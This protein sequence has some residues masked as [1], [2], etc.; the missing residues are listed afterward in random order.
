MSIDIDAHLPPLRGGR[1]G[2]WS[3]AADAVASIPNGSRVFVSGA[4][5]TPHVLLDALHEARSRWTDIEIVAPYL[6]TR[7]QVFEDPGRPFRFVTLQA[8]PAFKYLWS[9]GAVQV[10]PCAYSQFGPLCAAGG[11]HACDVALLHTSA[12]GP[13]GRV[14][15]GLSAGGIVDVARTAPL[16]IAQVNPHVPYTLGASELPV[17]AFDHLV[18]V[19]QPLRIVK[20]SESLDDVGRRIATTAASFV[21]EGAAIQFGVGAMPDAILSQLIGRRGLRVHSGMVSDACIDLYEAGAVEGPMITAEAVATA[22]MVRWIDRN[23]AVTMASGA[24]THGLAVLAGLH[25]F[26]SLNS[27]VEIALDGAC[28]SEIAGGQIISGPGGAP[29]YAQA[30]QLAPEGRAVLALRSSAAK[31]TVSRI[32]DRIE[33][34]NPTTLPAYFADVVVTEHGAAEVRGLPLRE[35]AEALIAIADPA[36]RDALRRHVD[37]NR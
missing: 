28:N 30:A 1:A 19:D 5:M 9:S 26:T 17:E 33:A 16:V 15:L 29:D 23:P 20:D 10:L 8:T 7:P 21:R 22:R 12:P 13:D 32:V 6:T 4:A 37:R 3:S 11:A 2:R 35:R 24:V 14:S 36:H 18:E 34:P 27:T 31:G 25:R